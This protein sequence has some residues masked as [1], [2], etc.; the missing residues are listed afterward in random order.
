MPTVVIAPNNITTNASPITFTFEF[1]EAVT[2]FFSSDVTVI[3]GSKGTF[4]AVDSDSYTLLVT[5]TAD[6][7][8]TVSIPSF[9]FQDLA[10]NSNDTTTSVSVTSERTPP[11]LTITPNSG[12]TNAATITYTFQFTETVTGFDATDITVTNGTKG[13]FTAVDGDTYTLVVTPTSDGLVTAS[14]GANAAQDGGSNGN[15]AASGSNTS[16]H[17]TPTLAITPNGTTSNASTLTFTFQFSETV[18]GFLASDVTVTNGT[19]GTF[20][21]VD[22]DTYTLVVT[23]VADGAV[24]VD[25]ASNAAREPATADRAAHT[26]EC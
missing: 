9:R 18:T 21:A 1:S 2:G 16:D 5:P 6:G 22:G 19:K 20:T 12:S 15:A 26:L 24:T 17:S 25:V 8:V 4:T 23:P 10:T 7:A 3:N 14:V 13:D 11:S